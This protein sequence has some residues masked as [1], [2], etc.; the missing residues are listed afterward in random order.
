M[1]SSNMS[2]NDNWRGTSL[3]DMFGE[4]APFDKNV[5]KIAEL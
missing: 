3:E 4:L 1:S 5:R 2:S